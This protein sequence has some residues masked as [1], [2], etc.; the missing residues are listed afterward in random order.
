MYWPEDVFQQPGVIEGAEELALLAPPL[1]VDNFEAIAAV[2]RGEGGVRL[3]IASDDNQ[4]D[5]QQTLLYAFD[6][7]SN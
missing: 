6:L 4:S 7:E 1:M 5:R 2:R 3:Y